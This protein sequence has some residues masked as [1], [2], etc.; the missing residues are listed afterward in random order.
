MSMFISF[1]L[2][3]TS[4]N[5]YEMYRL[6]ENQYIISGSYVYIFVSYER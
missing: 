6:N 5:V 2:K 1:F 4:K 3:K